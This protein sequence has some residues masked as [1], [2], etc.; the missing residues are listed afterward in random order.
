MIVIPHI[1]SRMNWPNATRDEFLIMGIKEADSIQYRGVGRTN[2]INTQNDFGKYSSADNSIGY[3][4][5]RPP[6]CDGCVVSE[7]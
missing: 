5:Y 6:S 3:I 1:P 4:I 7:R 2:G